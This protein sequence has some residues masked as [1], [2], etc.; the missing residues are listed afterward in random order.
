M[1][2]NP[3]N[4]KLTY[5]PGP[6]RHLADPTG[7]VPS[8]IGVTYVRPNTGIFA[9]TQFYGLDVAGGYSSRLASGEALN[10]K[11]NT[12]LLTG[13]LSYTFKRV[14]LLSNL[15]VDLSGD[16]MSAGTFSTTNRSV[17]AKLSFAAPLGEKTSATAA[18]GMATSTSK[19]LVEGGLALND[20]WETGTVFS[21]HAAKVGSEYIDPNFANQQF[22]FAGYDNFSR[23][24][25]NGI[26]NLE[27]ELVQSVSDQTRLVGKGSVRLNS[28]YKYQ[29]NKAKLTAQGGISHTVAPNVNVDANYRYYQDKSTGDTSDMASVGL[30]YKF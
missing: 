25:E 28:D 2:N 20:P 30:I 22:D 11:I 10:G 6:K 8:E 21:V 27:S 15:K 19:M 29:G 23:P 14:F 3:V 26:V 13:S 16:Y 7:L 24:L 12:S 4:L 1:A 17:R 5:G 18:V 9:T